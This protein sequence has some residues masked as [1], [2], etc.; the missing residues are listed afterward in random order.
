MN[1]VFVSQM[2][3]EYA[4]GTRIVENCRR[5]REVTIVSAMTAGAKAS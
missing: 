5:P 1:G 3:N 4:D 2:V